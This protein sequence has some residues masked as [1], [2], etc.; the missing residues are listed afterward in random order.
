MANAVQQL[1]NLGQSVWYDNISRGLITSG[2]LQ[3]LID[4]GVSGLTSNPTIFEKAIAGSKDYDA[5]LLELAESGR[6]TEEIYEA[7]VIEDIQAAA[8]H[9]RPVFERTG[10]ADGFACLEV[11]PHLAHNA[12]GTVG[13]ARRLFAA[14]GRPNVMVKVPGTPEGVIAIRQLIGD[15]I[16]INVT[17]IFS[18]DAY[19]DV[20]EAY[21][22]GLDD[23]ASSGG[24]VSGVASV[25]S[26]FVSR[27]D[28]AVDGLLE[29]QLRAGVKTLLGK[30]AVS[31]AKLAYRSFQAAFYSDR[32]ASLREKG[33]RVQRPLWASTGT[34][35]PAY[36][37]V[38][39]VESLVGKD[40]VN[41]M[42][43]ATLDA[44]IE[45]GRAIEAIETGV[46][47]A[48][49]SLRALEEAGIGM[50]QVTAKLLEDGLQSFADS[51]D[52]LL[53]N[54]EEKRSR[55]VAGG[56]IPV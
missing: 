5:A 37:D 55:L 2:E 28:T 13:E 53:V 3:R 12:E 6:S 19:S 1:Q 7:L 42:P 49:S 44:F 18:L 46:D 30:A 10:G 20:R 17:L 16:N 29:D 31:N 39:Y 43:E 50:E 25:A 52:K 22:A 47:K 40:T 21:L 36:S 24:D 4:L 32:F 56:E 9:L 48:E 45:H 38:L 54:I 41:T 11:S 34:K 8:D 35:N 14:L 23:L 26:F 51:Y 15:G 27:V 33:A